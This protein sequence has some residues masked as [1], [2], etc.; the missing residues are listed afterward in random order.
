MFLNLQQ[1]IILCVIKTEDAALFFFFREQNS[2]WTRDS[3]VHNRGP[4][5]NIEPRVL[6]SR[7]RLEFE[8]ETFISEWF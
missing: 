1:K 3:M 7:S 5:P 2:S 8:H 6:S 4:A